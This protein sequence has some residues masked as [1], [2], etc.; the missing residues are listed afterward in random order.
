MVRRCSLGDLV[1]SSV[2]LCRVAEN[3]AKNPELC[4]IFHHYKT[5]KVYYELG[6]IS[7]K[8]FLESKMTAEMMVQTLI[9]GK[10]KDNFLNNLKIFSGLD[11]KIT[12]KSCERFKKQIKHKYS[13]D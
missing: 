13:L 11:C 5:D 6:E 2:E 10:N 1:K 4:Q 12:E 3:R 7:E 8:T 9:C